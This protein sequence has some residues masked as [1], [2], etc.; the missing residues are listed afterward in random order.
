MECISYKGQKIESPLSAFNNLLLKIS[1]DIQMI[2]LD[3]CKEKSNKLF[4]NQ[5]LFENTSIT[6]FGCV[7]IYLKDE[8]ILFKFLGEFDTAKLILIQKTIKHE[9]QLKDIFST[10]LFMVSNISKNFDD[11]ISLK[12]IET[13][14]SKVLKLSKTKQDSELF[15][16][17]YK[18]K[19]KH[20]YDE[21][22]PLLES[23]YNRFTYL[24]KFSTTNKIFN[25]KL[26]RVLS[27]ELNES[28]SIDNL[29][30]EDI[31]IIKENSLNLELLNSFLIQLYYYGEL[32][33]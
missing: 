17:P 7:K 29:R 13:I 1:D 15:L 9:I 22:E 21:N 3:N 31:E 20:L 16:V 26:V 11:T 30:F 25:Y 32:I 23:L 10:Y 2:Y 27:S 18:N 28:K 19:I 12:F 6:I 33:E 5:L 8:N 24:I 14:Y 4:I